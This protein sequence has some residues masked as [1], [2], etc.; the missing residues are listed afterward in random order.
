MHQQKFPQ[1]PRGNVYA[2]ARFPQMMIK[3]VKTNLSHIHSLCTHIHLKLTFLPQHIFQAI[4]VT[5]GGPEDC[6][7]LLQSY[8]ALRTALLPVDS[9]LG[10]SK[11]VTCSQ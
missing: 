7:S 4:V 2:V 9:A 1:T 11:L 5:H 3:G 10:L 8:W 6:Y